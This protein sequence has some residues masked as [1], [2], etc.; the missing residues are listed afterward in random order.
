MWRAGLSFGGF[1]RQSRV[2]FRAKHTHLS[3][4]ANGL[5]A[6]IDVDL[7]AYGEV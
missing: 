5:V 3:N 2:D 6:D 7:G 4:A 1:G